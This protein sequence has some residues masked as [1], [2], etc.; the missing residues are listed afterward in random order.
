[1]RSVGTQEDQNVK[2]NKLFYAFCCVYNSN[3]NKN[4]IES[5]KLQ[6]LRF[7][8]GRIHD[9]TELRGSGRVYSE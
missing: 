3:S 1:M 9:K 8:G 2:F 7:E 5:T 6:N 4:Y